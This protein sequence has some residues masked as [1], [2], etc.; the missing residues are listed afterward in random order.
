LLRALKKLKTNK[1]AG[2]GGMKVKFIL[3]VGELLHMPL[4]RT[5]NC[6]LAKCFPKALFI[7][8]VH[9]FLK[10]GDAFEFDN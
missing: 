7:G 3:D 5:F 10:G 9:A 8:M 1:V 4:L 2:L 6:F